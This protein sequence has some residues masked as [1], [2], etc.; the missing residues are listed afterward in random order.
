MNIDK[1]FVEAFEILENQGVIESR[2]KIAQ[3]FGYKP[4]AFTEI[5][6]G[7]SRVNPYLLSDFC[8]KFGISTSWLLYGEGEMFESAKPIEANQ[9]KAELSEIKQMVH[10]LQNRLEALG[11]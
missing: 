10:T 5:L 9:Y 6:K 2:T 3:E 4:Q 8:R 7:R 11:A 1:R